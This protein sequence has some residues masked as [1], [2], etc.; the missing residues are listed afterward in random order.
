M[1]LR[2]RGTTMKNY[3][4]VRA[5]GQSKEKWEEDMAPTS[6]GLTNNDNSKLVSQ[7][8]GEQRM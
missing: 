8:K 1:E 5:W 7:C 4:K 6:Q 3:T 2:L